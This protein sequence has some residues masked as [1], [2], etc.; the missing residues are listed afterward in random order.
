MVI[1]HVIQQYDKQELKFNR[2]N[3][4]ALKTLN[5]KVIPDFCREQGR[6]ITINDRGKRNDSCI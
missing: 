1:E 5:F 4:S 3:G 2:R 6:T